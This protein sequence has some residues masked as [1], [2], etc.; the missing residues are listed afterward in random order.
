[1]LIPIAFLISSVWPIASAH[2]ECVAPMMCVSGEDV[3]AAADALCR[4]ARAVE[5]TAADLV[6]DKAR[7]ER[8]RDRCE[9]RLLAAH[10]R[11]ND[12]Q[13]TQ[14]ALWL[15]IVLDASSVALASASVACLLTDECPDTIGAGLAVGGLGALGV[16][17]ALEF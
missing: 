15:R 3:N 7:L 16:R 9:G 1:M 10:D 5:L 2:A 14:P 8:E 13:T 17:I 4:R 12:Q 11:L 6:E